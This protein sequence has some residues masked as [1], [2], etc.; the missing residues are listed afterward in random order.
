MHRPAPSA[1]W[2]L[3]Y[4]PRVAILSGNSSRSAAAHVLD[5]SVAGDVATAGVANQ[6]MYS[7]RASTV[8][9]TRPQLSNLLA[10][11][12]AAA[13][14][15]NVDG[16]KIVDF[17]S[18][19]EILDGRRLAIFRNSG[20]TNAGLRQF[21]KNQKAWFARRQSFE[22]LW[23]NGRSFIYGAANPGHE[24][25]GGTYGP[26]CLVIRPARVSGSDSAVFPGN[27]ARLYGRRTGG[28]DAAGAHAQAGSWAF[29][30]DVVVATF[31][32]A[33]AP[34]PQNLWPRLVCN[35]TEFIE[36][37]TAGPVAF[38]DVIE[39]RITHSHLRDLNAWSELDRRGK[40]TD[41]SKQN[42]VAGWRTV[43]RWIRATHP[44]I[45]RTIV[46]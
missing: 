15:T 38:T 45:A 20:N 21:R 34:R 6:G 46:R 26:F 8:L 19:G 43:K 13:P 32:T 44:H 18:A 40:L 33:I 31:G 17:D 5:V 11:L 1:A 27:T 4:W 2:F 9:A 30:E 35:E 25:T 23:T 12:T 16:G 14:T 42:G 7:G 36:V 22:D 41:T 39:V 24:G 37:V 10:G 28:A 3:R 29:V